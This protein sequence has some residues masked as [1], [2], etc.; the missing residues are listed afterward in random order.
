M[1][2]VKKITLALT[3]ALAPLAASAQHYS[4]D[5][6]D[7]KQGGVHHHNPIKMVYGAMVGIDIPDMADRSGVN[8]ISNSVGARVGMMWGVDLGGVELVP[9]LWYIHNKADITNNNS[10]LTGQLVSNSIEVPI[11]FAIPFAD[12]VRFNVGPS[13]SLMSEGQLTVDGYDDTLEFGRMKS[14]CGYTIGLSGLVWQHMIIDARFTGRFATTSN[15]SFNDIEA[16]E[17]HDYRYFSFAVNI[18][19]RF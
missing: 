11:L 4:Q 1:K 2:I 16:V 15:M 5:Y 3:L 19:Y 8:D 12:I 14:T 7:V 18:G 10:G 6:V 17:Q 9:E 13:F